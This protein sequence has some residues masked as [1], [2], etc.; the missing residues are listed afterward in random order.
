MEGNDTVYVVR[1]VMDM[2]R[3]DLSSVLFEKNK[4]KI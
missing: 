4:S 2:Y 3:F 1:I